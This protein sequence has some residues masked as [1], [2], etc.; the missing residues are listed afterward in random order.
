MRTSH[1]YS[2]IWQ[3]HNVC[4][5]FLVHSIWPKSKKKKL[6]NCYLLKLFVCVRSNQRL[7]EKERKTM[8]IKDVEKK[9]KIV[10]KVKQCVQRVWAHSNS[11]YRPKKKKKSSQKIKTTRTQYVQWSFDEKCIPKSKNLSCFLYNKTKN[12]LHIFEE[13][14]NDS[15]IFLVLVV[16][17]LCYWSLKHFER[18]NQTNKRKQKNS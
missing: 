5:H 3:W 11:Q 13:S 7:R 8:G 15:C 18:R 12:L 10:T 6:E 4:F 1:T 2:T 16:V 14:M 9:Q 17:G